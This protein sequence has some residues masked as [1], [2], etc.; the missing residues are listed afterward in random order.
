MNHAGCRPVKL[1][2]GASLTASAVLF[3]G[4]RFVIP[5]SVISV[6]KSRPTTVSGRKSFSGSGTTA[7]QHVVF[8]GY[9]QEKC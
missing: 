1:I 9:V 7:V 3:T 4:I 8:L 2:Q 6:M 5:D